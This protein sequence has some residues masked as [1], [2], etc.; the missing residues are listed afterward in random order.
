MLI[1]SF[2]TESSAPLWAEAWRYGKQSVEHHS[3]YTALAY[4]WPHM[5]IVE[6]GDII[7]GGMEY[8]MLTLIGDYEGDEAQELFATVSHEIA[9]MWVPMIAAPNEKRYAWIDEGSATFLENQSSDSLWPGVDH[10]RVEARAY[11][12]VAAAGAEQSMMRHADWYEPGN[13][14]GVA[15]YPKAATLMVALRDVLG[16]ETWEGAYRAFLSEWAFKHPTPWDFFST[17]ERFAER[18]LDWLWTSFYYETW[19]LDHAVSDVTMR[20]G[21]GATIVI[22][23]RGLAFFP[24][25]VRIRTT[26]GGTLEREVPVEHWLAGNRSYTITLEP[27]AGAVTRVELDP[28]GY[29]PDVDRANNLWPR[30]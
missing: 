12:Q 13:G 9:H 22:E 2:W 28:D 15:S 4:P 7:G 8:P 1:H 5:T 11:L 10:H 19:T 17:F 30:G 14:Y 18:D 26:G 21:R 29:A 25:K 23:D 3:M 24:A 6:G 16:R 27:S 20:A